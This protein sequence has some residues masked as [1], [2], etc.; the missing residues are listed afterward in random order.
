MTRGNWEWRAERENIRRAAAKLKK[1]N[2]GSP[3]SVTVESVARSLL[4]SEKLKVYD[5]H[6]RAWV[7]TESSDQP[8]CGQWFRSES[9]DS[10]K[11]RKSHNLSIADLRNTSVITDDNG[12]KEPPMECVMLSNVA[13]SNFVNIQYLA[14]DDCL[15]FDNHC[16]TVWASWRDHR[17]QEVNS[18]KKLNKITESAH[19]EDTTTVD[20]I[21]NELNITGVDRDESTKGTLFDM[22]VFECIPCEALELVVVFGDIMETGALCTTSTF[23]RNFFMKNSIA[24]NQ[25]KEY[26]SAVSA[27]ASRR[28]K[29]EKK[30]KAKNA[31]IK[32]TTKKDGFARGQCF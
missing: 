24:R 16:S 20:R 2:R 4:S 31:H 23:F 11:C 15:V 26:L 3:D 7:F 13:E 1:A 12:N 19:E 32:K 27:Q 21:V 25:R 5:R 28:K 14:V 18:C 9:C 17:I 29:E 30:K 6:L 8:V 22:I 10:K